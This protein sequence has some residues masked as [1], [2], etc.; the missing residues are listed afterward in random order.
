[1]KQLKVDTSS[2]LLY[3]KKLEPRDKDIYLHNIYLGHQNMSLPILVRWKIKEGMLKE[4]SKG[5]GVFFG[6][7]RQP[8]D[9]EWDLEYLKQGLAFYEDLSTDETSKL[10]YAWWWN[11][12]NLLEELLGFVGLENIKLQKEGNFWTLPGVKFDLSFFDEI[13]LQ[14]M[15]SFVFGG[16]LLR[17]DFD[18]VDDKIVNLKIFWPVYEDSKKKILLKV[19]EGLGKEVIAVK[20]YITSKGKND[21]IQWS[22]DDEELLNLFANWIWASSVSID[23]L[24]WLKEKF[25]LPSEVRYIKKVI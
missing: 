19:K 12:K 23:L 14:A 20:E 24:K 9:F 10:A 21:I 11:D 16:A 13:N 22:I 3:F 8:I 5:E 15:I 2:K 1:M 18:V 4:L 6:L 7:Q 17:G 25:Q